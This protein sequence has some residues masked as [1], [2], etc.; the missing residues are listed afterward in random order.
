MRIRA[1]IPQTGLV[2][3]GLL[4]MAC[5]VVAGVALSAQ[6][7]AANTGTSAFPQIF[8]PFIA[9]KAA[10]TTEGEGEGEG[11]GEPPPPALESVTLLSPRGNVVAPRST[12]TVTVFFAA[13]VELTED[14]P[15]N[16]VPVVSFVLDGKEHPA[17]L[18]NGV[19][20]TVAELPMGTSHKVAAKAQVGS[21]AE[22]E[23][24][25]TLEVKQS[26]PLSFGVRF[27][28]DLDASGY[29]DNPFKA[30]P[31]AGDE[32]HGVYATDS[33]TRLVFVASL[34]TSLWPITVYMANPAN[35]S[36]L[37]AVTIPAGLIQSNER[38]L[39]MLAKACDENTLYAPE[40]A[41]TADERPGT[42][43]PGAGFWESHLIV[44]ADA[45]KT[46]EEIGADRLGI[47]PLIMQ[48]DGIRP[49]AGNTTALYGRDAAVEGDGTTGLRVIAGDAPWTRDD[50]LLLEPPETGGSMVAEISRAGALAVFQTPQ[51][52]RL[53][54]TPGGAA[55]RFGFGI[56]PAT[57]AITQAFLLTNTGSQP[58]TGT[59]TLDD[60]SGVFTIEQP[61]NYTLAPGRSVTVHLQFIPPIAGDY[62]AALT[63]TGGETG[64]QT[65]TITGSGGAKPPKA[66]TAFG[67]RGNDAAGV[68]G[69]DAGDL[70]AAAAALALLALGARRARA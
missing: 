18:R 52:P 53:V 51:P 55:G 31:G 50:L 63:F 69:G 39:L 42:I 15:A 68:S 47:Q 66:V 24:D 14:A 61:P 20:Q 34:R 44:S 23:T 64:P 12:H 43:V 9:D 28:D 29:P 1:R 32:W 65:M 3:A 62:I 36:Q 16:T 59:M 46:F 17:V 35:L 22:G 7:A 19:W 4:A 8:Q 70:L 49:S 40:T 54:V 41:P 37:W 11:E 58:L 26:Q 6:T 30:L 27:A 45:G 48:W 13:G 56:V 60:P 57:Q 5:L 38:A 67:C 2:L 33:C 25:S 10:V 21:A